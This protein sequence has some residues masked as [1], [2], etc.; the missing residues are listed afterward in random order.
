MVEDQIVAFMHCKDCVEEIPNGVSPR[1]WSR[2]Q[3]G[4]TKIGV[5]VWC[6]RH[7]QNLVH[8]DFEGQKHPAE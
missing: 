7:E 5:Q 3:V 8:I 4:W 1:D 6:I 2:I